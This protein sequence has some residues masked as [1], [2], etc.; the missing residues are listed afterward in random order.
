M[1]PDLTVEEL[2][3]LETEPLAERAAAL[4]ALELELRAALD[5]ATPA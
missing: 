2:D 5:D 3:R 1:E 4:E